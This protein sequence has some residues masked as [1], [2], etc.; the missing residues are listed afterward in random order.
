VCLVV[1]AHLTHSEIP[2]CK[3]CNAWE[4]I[5]QVVQTRC[6]KYFSAPNY[7]WPTMSLFVLLS[8]AETFDPSD[9]WFLSTGSRQR[10]GRKS[11]VGLHNILL[12]YIGVPNNSVVRN[13]EMAGNRQVFQV[14]I[15]SFLASGNLHLESLKLSGAPCFTP[16]TTDRIYNAPQIPP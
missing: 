15:H 6:L 9:I 11:F 5:D 12:R 14:V 2:I 13:R 1:I 3:P 10:N 16:D 7:S 8:T 4:P